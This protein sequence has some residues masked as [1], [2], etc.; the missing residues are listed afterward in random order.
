MSGTRKRATLSYNAH[1]AEVL[2]GLTGADLCG[3]KDQLPKTPSFR[4]QIG[5]LP[6]RRRY[7]SR[8]PRPG[9]LPGVRQPATR[10][11]CP[12]DRVQTTTDEGRQDCASCRDFPEVGPREGALSNKVIPLGGAASHRSSGQDSPR[13]AAPPIAAFVYVPPPRLASRGN[14][15][16][17][18]SSRVGAAYRLLCAFLLSQF[19]LGNRGVSVFCRPAGGPS[20]CTLPKATRPVQPTDRAE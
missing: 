12:Q 18:V 19:C 4:S 11:R 1:P 2:S 5:Q 16:R 15:F 17:S 7:G 9:M 13:S 3:R 6:D 14:S 8:A 20:E 10:R